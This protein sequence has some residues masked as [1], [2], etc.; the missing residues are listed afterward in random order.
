MSDKKPVI[1]ISYAHAD[2]PEKPLGGEVQWLSF[3]RR[4]LQPAVKDGIFDLWVDRHMLGGADWDDEIEQKLRACDIFILLVSAYSMASN[5]V[6]D[7][8]IA[9]IRERQTAGELV[10][11]YPLLLTPTPK[12]GL[13]KVRD[14]NLRPRDA[15]PFSGYATHD[16]EQHMTDAA[17]E[18]A[19]IA[20]EIT[21]KKK[22]DIERKATDHAET[23]PAIQVVAAPP[24]IL[25][26]V[27]D[28]S[29]GDI[30]ARKTEAVVVDTSHLPETFYERLVGR[31]EQLEYLDRT[32]ADRNTNILSL[33]AEGGAGKSA[34]VNEWLKRLQADSYRGAAT[35]LGWSFYSQGSKERATSAEVFLDWA[36]E[37]LGIKIETTSANAKGEAIA[38]AMSQR[39]LLLVLDGCEPL[40]HGLDKQQGELKDQG[41]RAL[42]RRF[43]AMPPTEMH[44]LIV[45]TS[46]LPVKD[47][48][49]W[50][51]SA[52]PVLNV[53]QLSDE[54]GAALLRD[55]GVWGTDKE[56]LAAARDF[57]GHP[58]ALG[59]LASFLKEKHFGDDRSRGHLRQY[60][61]K[62]AL[63]AD[64][65][66]PRHDHA[67][68]VMESY[69]AEW[70]AGEAVEHAIMHTV[71]LFDRPASSDCLWALRGKP[72]IPGLTDALVD[73]DEDKWQRAVTRLR[74]ARLLAPVDPSAPDALDAHPLVRE[75]FGERL[76]QTKEP[77]WKAAHGRLYEHLRDTTKEGKTPTLE[78]LAPLYQAISHGCRAG[79][80]QEVLDAVYARR[81]CLWRHDGRFMF[82]SINVLG[83]LGTDL[84]A[85]SWFFEKPYE[86]PVATLAEE[87]QNWVLSTA[88]FLLRAQG[89]FTE[90]L[91]AQRASLR[92]NEAAKR[93]KNAANSASNLSES[94][95]LV[96]EIAVAMAAAK[97]SVAHADRS[98]DVLRKIVGRTTL[99]GT[100]HAAGRCA[101]AETLFV[102]AERLQCDWQ[103]TEP[104]LYS[105]RGYQYCDLLLTKGDLDL[106]RDRATKILESEVEFDTLL[107][108]ALARLSCGRTRLA[109]ILANVSR[110]LSTATTSSDVRSAY[111]FFN[112]ALDYL[113]TSGQ[114]DDVPRGLFAR[115]SFCRSL[116]DWDRAARDLDEVEEIAEPGPMRLHLCDMALECARL[117]F[118]KIEAFAPLNGLID[119]SPPKPVVPD[120]AEVARLKEEAAKQLATAAD[121]IKTCG[122]HRRD[123]E[124]A[125]LEAVLRGERKFADL[126]PRV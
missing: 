11:F 81:I 124:L 21:D 88:S 5:Y 54:A 93:W 44:G 68:R 87:H 4:F 35:V 123:A 106:A 100:L 120:A 83:A 56:L 46:R 15:T 63:L 76:R 31:K 58:L 43:A 78:D 77:A 92:M 95:L 42:L 22:A 98:N 20:A 117:A 39:R 47:I 13:V 7:K 40:Q 74:D 29:R 111:F 69:E 45:L 41:L 110:P 112:L 70:L 38:E 9:I 27:A 86:T 82:Y 37:K 52:A 25:A 19:G 94:E 122:Y 89:R 50:K 119:D 64:P 49:R 23:V 118:A 97:Q 101:E 62:L 73:L 104:M 90:A 28:N 33:I 103:P 32:W 71:G 14:K 10:Y 55:N 109:S 60:D 48:A 18:I 30:E 16:R 17:D 66:N 3:V 107:D 108:R 8:E 79:R 12:A 105:M 53:E 67:R 59:L 114:N 126:L 91:Y 121:Y 96:G 1:F 125:E 116:G 2:E 57:G 75:W 102:Y 80:H 65:E 26:G 99:A 61:E 24:E 72:A 84:A 36:L 6:V 34:L 51:D 115:A 85:I 113:R